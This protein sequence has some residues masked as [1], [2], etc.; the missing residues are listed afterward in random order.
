[1]AKEIVTLQNVE[2]IQNVLG[3]C[4]TSHHGFP[5]L[6][7]RGNVVGL[8]PKNY[9]VT[10]LDSRAFYRVDGLVDDDDDDMFN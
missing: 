3:A 1:M 2:T 10:L 6:N 7:S 8:I 4:K 5:I 9:A